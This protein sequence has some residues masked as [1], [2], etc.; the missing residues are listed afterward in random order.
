MNMEIKNKKVLFID[1]DGTLVKTITGSS[2]PVGVWDVKLRLEV[3]SQIKSLFSSLTHLFVVTNQGGIEKGYVNPDSFE[4]KFEW[5]LGCL[6]DWMK[7]DKVR[8]LIVGGAVCPTNDEK[9]YRRKPNTGMLQDLVDHFFPNGGIEKQDMVMIGDASGKEGDFSDSD[10]KTAENMGI[11]YIDVEEFLKI[12][13]SGN[14]E[15]K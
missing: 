3:F 13:E 14:G 12:K 11:D 5:V 6:S 15:G 7:G 2:H 8:E 4:K 1:L 9:Y 10:R